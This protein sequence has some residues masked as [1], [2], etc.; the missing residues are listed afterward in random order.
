MKLILDSY[1]TDSFSSNMFNPSSSLY[2]QANAVLVSG[3]SMVMSNSIFRSTPF[4]PVLLGIFFGF[5]LGCR[6]ST[7]TIITFQQASP[8]NLY[9]PLAF[10]VGVSRFEGLFFHFCGASGFPF[11]ARIITSF[12]PKIYSQLVGGFIPSEK[13]LLNFH[14]FPKQG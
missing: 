9:L 5:I 6:P 8:T 4:E 14:Q 12:D 11:S 3:G 10:S 2:S 13:L 1:R 7:I